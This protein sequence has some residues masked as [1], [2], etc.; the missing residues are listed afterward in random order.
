VLGLGSQMRCHVM[1]RFGMTRATWPI[2]DL[3][4]VSGVIA[5]ITAD[6]AKVEVRSVAEDARGNF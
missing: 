2:G 4:A 3:S 1:R 5:P 6:K